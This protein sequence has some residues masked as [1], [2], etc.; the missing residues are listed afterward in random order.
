[1]E[2]DVARRIDQ[3]QLVFLAAIRIAHGD[4]PGLDRDAALAF[5]V[6]VVERLF[7]HL[8]LLDGA[9]QFQQSIG[10]RAF[11]VVDM[12]DDREVADMLSFEHKAIV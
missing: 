8:A 3:I 12:G 7:A 5:E 4:G 9:G 6:H 1:M 10:Q 2:I 11:A